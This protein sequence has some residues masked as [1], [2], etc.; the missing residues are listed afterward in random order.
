[1]AGAAGS[2]GASAAGGAGGAGRAFWEGEIYLKAATYN[3]MIN[4]AESKGHTAMMVS[5][6]AA[7]AAGGRA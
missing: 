2:A 3:D 1:M 6:G 7:G 4:P 5:S